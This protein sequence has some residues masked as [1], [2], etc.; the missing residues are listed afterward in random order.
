MARSNSAR[1][2]AARSGQAIQQ[3]DRQRA[4]LHDEQ[5]IHRMRAPGVGGIAQAQHLVID[6]QAAIAIL[7]KP[8][9]TVD[10]GNVKARAL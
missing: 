5:R 4:P 9:Q 2:R 8:G 1:A 3:G 10:V 6:E 7:G